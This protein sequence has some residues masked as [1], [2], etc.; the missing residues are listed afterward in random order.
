MGSTMNV[1]GNTAARMRGSTVQKCSTTWPWH[2]Y[3]ALPVLILIFLFFQRIA[4][5]RARVHFFVYVCVDC[6][7]ILFPLPACQTLMASLLSSV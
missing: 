7:A 2:A 5:V 4:D 1:S 3:G 6:N